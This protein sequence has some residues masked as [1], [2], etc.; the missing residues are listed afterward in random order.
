MNQLKALEK[1]NNPGFKLLILLP[2]ISFI[3]SLVLVRAEFSFKVIYIFNLALIL[4]QILLFV[5]DRQFL[6][7]KQAF[8]PAWEWFILFPVYVYKRQSNNFLNLNYF[9]L[10]LLFFILNAVI[11]AYAKTL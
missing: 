10:S 11:G 3:G 8:C 2:L 9:Y 4:L 1:L 6:R 5:K 7:K